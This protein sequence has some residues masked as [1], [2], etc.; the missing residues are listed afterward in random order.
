MYCTVKNDERITNN[1]KKKLERYEI[2]NNLNPRKQ[3]ES[4]DF[5]WG[6]FLNIQDFGG[7]K[8]FDTD[9]SQTLITSFLTKPFL[10]SDYELKFKRK[11]IC[12]VGYN[13]T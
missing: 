4:T 6:A 10:A 9:L 11:K 13:Y 1:S 7:I 12:H 2:K 5:Q 8:E 3:W